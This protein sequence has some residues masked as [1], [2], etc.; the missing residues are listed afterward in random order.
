MPHEAASS[1]TVKA[2]GK[3]PYIRPTPRIIGGSLVRAA[4]TAV[5]AHLCNHLRGDLSLTAPACAALQVND[6]NYKFVVRLMET[7]TPPTPSRHQGSSQI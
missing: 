1:S 2:E 3:L 5:A 7:G 6:Y 4:A